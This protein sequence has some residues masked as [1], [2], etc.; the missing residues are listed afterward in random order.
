VTIA[1]SRRRRTRLVCGLGAA[2]LLLAACGSGGAGGSAA[3]SQGSFD[4]LGQTENTT[5]AAT[6]K[7]LSADSCKPQ[8]DALSLKTSSSPGG[9]FD[10]K[11]QLLSGQGALPTMSMGVGTPSLMKEFIKGKQVEDLEPGLDR[12][13][14]ADAV[15]PAARATLKALYGDQ[16]LYALPTEFNIEGFWYNKKIFQDN[17]I[18][19]PQTWDE[20]VTALGRL[21]A[22]GVQP[23]AA[24]GKTGWQIT[25]LIGDYIARDL[26]PDALRRVADGQAKLT[27]P[28]YV[29]AADA[30]AAIGRQGAFGKS[31][32]SID[33]NVAMNSF[34]T[35][36]SAMMYNGSWG[37]AN[38][39]DEKQNK[40]GVA[41]I[42]Y[43]PFPAVT[44]GKGSISDVPANVGVPVIFSGKRFN[45][46]VQDW[47]TCIAQNYG[48]RALSEEG[49]VSGFAIKHAPADLPP[50][51]RIVQETSAGAGSSI[52][53]FEAL[54]SAKATT[55]SQQSA[56]PLATG[57]L[58]G[59][60]F[61]SRVQDAG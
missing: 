55:V 22:A 43:L 47:V 53:W 45:A 11:L 46:E 60:E 13:G 52:L 50:L 36:K 40:I 8:N 26:G 3:G 59:A 25:R 14:A 5:I 10:Q 42:G 35:G 18:A 57:R 34:L 48:D 17:E 32:G 28:Q 49:V 56:A 23:I 1:V 19:V 12:A 27:D 21:E 15:L 33:Y 39:N 4:Y 9:Q 7:S 31:P 38:Y 54:F 44:G 30:V 24:D 41:T 29:R 58:S 20:L 37:L 16:G 6:L 2:G 61:M 51:T